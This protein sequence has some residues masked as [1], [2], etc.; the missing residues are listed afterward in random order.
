M[1]VKEVCN[2]II[3]QLQPQ[4]LP[5]PSTDTWSKTAEGFY[6]RW[7]YPNC[8]GSID[9]KHVAIKC[10]SNSGST[11]FCYKNIY[12]IVLLSIVDHDYKFICV[13]VGGYGKNSDGGIFGESAMGKK[14]S[15][16]QLNFPQDK[17]LPG[18][19]LSSPYC[20]IGD[21]AFAL[22]PNLMKPFSQRKANEDRRKR[23]YNYRLCRARGVVE[24]TFGILAQKWRLYNR[25]LEINVEFCKV[26]VMA[27]CVLHNF[28]RMK[29]SDTTF[30]NCLKEEP[31]GQLGGGGAFYRF[32]PSFK[33][34]SRYSMIVRERFVDFFNK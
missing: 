10:P 22:K 28:L 25:P 8:V 24:N 30:F 7:Q 16:N 12:S 13:D 1:I 6:E 14:F 11:Y 2:A 20:L 26:V 15:T 33:S 27:T 17:P 32:S 23:R 21:E 18:Q 5:E 34:S 3:Q 9:G 4:Y 31:E 29:N 19:T